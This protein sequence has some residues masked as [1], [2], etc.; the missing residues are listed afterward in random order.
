M[1]I[2]SN[3]QVDRDSGIRSFEL[4]K[5]TE[6]IGDNAIFEFRR[7]GQDDERTEAHFTMPTKNLGK[8]RSYARTCL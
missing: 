1:Q 3:F 6:L 2:M 4:S 8:Q 5:L 7:C